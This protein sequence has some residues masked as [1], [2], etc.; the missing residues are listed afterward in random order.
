MKGLKAVLSDKKFWVAL[1]GLVAGI[2]VALGVSE[3]T[4]ATVSGGALSVVSVVMLALMG[5][6]TAKTAATQQ[7]SPDASLFQKEPEE[8]DQEEE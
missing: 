2:A 7:E 4:V 1:V 8:S 3:S 5:V 6:K